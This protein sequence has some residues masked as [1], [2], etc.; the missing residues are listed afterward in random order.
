MRSYL[1]CF[2]SISLILNGCQTTQ[3][4]GANTFSALNQPVESLPTYTA[5]HNRPTSQSSASLTPSSQTAFLQR[6]DVQSFIQTTHQEHQ[7]PVAWLEQAL[8]KVEL[9]PAIIEAMNKPAESKTWGQYRPIFMTEA[10]IRNGVAFWQQN[11]D[12]LKAAEAQ[13]GVPAEI[14]VAI[15]GVETS[16]GANKGKWR[17]LD[18]LST[19]A[20]DYPRRADFFRKELANFLV[21]AYENQA[22]AT[23]YLGSYAGAMGFPQFMPSSYRHYAVDFTQ[24][25]RRDL[26]DNPA[27]AIGSVANYLRENGWQPHE[28]IAMPVT[29]NN[30]SALNYITTGAIK[31]P[32][33]AISTLTQ[34][35]VQL[36]EPTQLP[37]MLL[38]YEN[39]SGNEYWLGFNNFY[40]I[41]RYNRSPLYALAVYQLADAIR[42][43]L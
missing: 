3:T 32:T 19:L 20:F 26:W 21:I 4:T 2:L 42:S 14:I 16:Y 10:R 9:K 13:Y 37:A 23:Q 28:K 27:D 43:N 38:Q 5:N 24:D 11:R 17:V 41:T 39:I 36:S 31:K 12:S 33:H 7:L 15:I 30:N 40:V 18:A 25:G 8:S 35:G 6:A 22:D 1:C 29:L 34:A